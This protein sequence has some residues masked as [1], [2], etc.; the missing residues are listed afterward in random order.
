M[1]VERLQMGPGAQE[2]QLTLRSGEPIWN[3]LHKPDLEARAVCDH[4]LGQDGRGGGGSP[5]GGPLDSSLTLLKAR[6]AQKVSEGGPSSGSTLF[7]GGPYNG[8]KWVRGGGNRG[9]L[10]EAYGL[11]PFGGDLA[12]TL[13]WGRH[14]LLGGLIRR[15]PGGL[16]SGHLG[17]NPGLSRSLDL[18]LAN[19]RKICIWRPQAPPAVLIH[20]RGDPPGAVAV[21]AHSGAGGRV[22]QRHLGL[23][24][25]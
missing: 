24:F 17:P 6:A 25:V 9:E 10:F 13:D 3:P 5:A 22:G 18:M 15:L 23:S 2:P 20:L 11:G 19:A 14:R 8:V 7:G 12:G 1:R 16:L 21:L 4:L